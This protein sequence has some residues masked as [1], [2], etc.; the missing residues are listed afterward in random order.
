[1]SICQSEERG[2][3]KGYKLKGYMC[4]GVQVKGGMVNCAN[5]PNN[6]DTNP[7][8]NP[9]PNCNPDPIPNKF[10]QSNTHMKYARVN[11]ACI[12]GSVTGPISAR[13]YTLK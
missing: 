7:N 5:N 1:M 3:R 12:A 13:A 6:S 11:N 10:N 4:I 9:D 2:C 8:P